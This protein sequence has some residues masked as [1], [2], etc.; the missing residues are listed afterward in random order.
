MA[1]LVKWKQRRDKYNDDIDGDLCDCH[2]PRLS[3]TFQDVEFI[4]RDETNA[5]AMESMKIK[6]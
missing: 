1:S 6:W 2:S 3:G 5:K 4:K